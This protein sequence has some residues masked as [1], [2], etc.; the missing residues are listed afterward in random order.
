MISA[1][2]VIPRNQKLFW[3]M[4]LSSLDMS[5]PHAEWEDHD[6]RDHIRKTDSELKGKNGYQGAW[7]LTVGRSKKEDTKIIAGLL[8]G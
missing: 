4:D 2:L 6:G 1:F 7:V 8:Q 3:R 5:S